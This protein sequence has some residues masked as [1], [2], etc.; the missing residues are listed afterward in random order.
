MG[1]A[2][3]VRR[4]AATD[5]RLAGEPAEFD[6]RVGAGPG[7]P[8]GRAVDDAEQRP[9]RQLEAGG[10]PRSQ[11]LP[12]PGIHADLAA[13]TAL[14]VAHEQRPAP[15]VEI[16]LAERQRL[17][18][19]QAAAPE[20]HDQGA[21]PVAVG[22]IVGLSHHGNDLFHGRWVGGIEPPLVAGRTSGVVAG[23]GRRRATPTRGI[24]HC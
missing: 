9:D 6:A 10:E 17:G 22:V 8:T 15:A 14:A 7:P 1:V 19:A 3:L 16:A 21:E 11:L 12:A 23:H 20:D 24:E 13:A 5:T 2:E 4:E 18:D